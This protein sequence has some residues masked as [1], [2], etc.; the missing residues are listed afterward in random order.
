MGA[1]TILKRKG[2][3]SLPYTMFQIIYSTRHKE[4]GDLIMLSDYRIMSREDL[5]YYPDI[6][7]RKLHCNKCGVAI[8]PT[9]FVVIEN[10][11]LSEKMIVEETPIEEFDKVIESF[12]KNARRHYHN[13]A[14]RL[15][16]NE[17]EKFHAHAVTGGVTNF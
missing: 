17:G 12:N 15:T 14:Q 2:R 13:A 16:L 11:R 9:R 7:P 1:L 10:V 8:E 4:C 6:K 3:F 5:K